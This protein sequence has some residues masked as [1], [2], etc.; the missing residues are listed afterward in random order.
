[1]I[2][3]PDP[4][5][6]PVEGVRRK[7]K[8]LGNPKY[9][10][11]VPTTCANACQSDPQISYVIHSS[12]VTQSSGTKCFGLFVYGFVYG[13][14]FGLVVHYFAYGLG[15]FV[16]GFVY[17]F[18]LFVYGFVYGFGLFVHGF[19]YGFGW[20]VHGFVYGFGSVSYTQSPS[21]RDGLLSR[22]PSSA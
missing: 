22:M 8:G 2:R 10:V 9:P 16:H 15:L 4:A 17:G 12:Y 1:M 20:F 13:F 6:P 21:P 3:P 14:G 7:G 19:V 18:G 11:T 5:T